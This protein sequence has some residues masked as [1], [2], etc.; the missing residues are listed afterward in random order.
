[1]YTQNDEEKWILDF[2]KDFAGRFIDLGAHNGLDLS[3]SR[4]LVNLGWKGICIE[5]SPTPFC[6]L[7]G[8]YSNHGAVTVVNCAVD[9]ESKLKPFYDNNGGYVSTLSKEHSVYWNK[10]ARSC[11]QGLY[12]KTIRFVE[13]LDCFGNDFNFLKIDAEGLDLA[14]LK[15]IPFERLPDLNMICI[16]HGKDKEAM[17]DVGQRNGF[18]ELTTTAHNLL[19]VR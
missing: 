2:Y 17:L 15:D 13:L 8:R 11:F 9:V 6:A 1:M 10:E 14:I 7:L 18:R 16:E 5:P 3:T 19:M 12:L 4:Q